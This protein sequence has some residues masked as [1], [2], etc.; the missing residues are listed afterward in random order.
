MCQ[1]D[2]RCPVGRHRPETVCPYAGTAARSW[3]APSWAA[4]APARVPVAPAVRRDRIAIGTNSGI[5]LAAFIAALVVAA[6]ADDHASTTSLVTLAGL[7]VVP[8]VVA[9]WLTERCTGWRVSGE[10]R[11]IQR[12]RGLG[13]RCADHRRQYVTQYDFAALFAVVVMLVNVVQLLKLAAG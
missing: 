8:L 2:R 4:P 3:A 11:C 6:A 5:C 10:E 7:V 13:T 12:R 9:A 1:Y